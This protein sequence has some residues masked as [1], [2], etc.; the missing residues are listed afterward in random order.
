LLRQ[1][2]AK[3]RDRVSLDT[4]RILSALD[5]KRLPPTDPT[6]SPP[7]GDLLALLD[8]MITSLAAFGGTV[9]ESMTRGR[10]WRFLDMGRR[11]ERSI[12]TVSLLRHT[13]TVAHVNEGPLL[14][15][16]LEVAESSMTYRRRYLAGMQAAPVVDLLLADESNPRSLAFQLVALAEHV[17]N[18]PRERPGA[19]RSTDQRIVLRA[20]TALRLADAHELAVPGEDGVRRQFDRLLS[21]LDS[22]FPG[23]GDS[24]TRSYFTH[25]T[26]SR[27]LAQSIPLAADPSPPGPQ[28]IV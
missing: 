15:A 9:A 7:L 24:I 3:V 23:L 25:V 8:E 10:G 6:G 5:P 4:W 13:L 2:A 14:E 22:D 1:V 20:L 27:Q 11:L 21:D 16:L 18:L 12:N 26:P 17:D 19:V 28:G